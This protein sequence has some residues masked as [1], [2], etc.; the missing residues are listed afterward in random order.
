MN[1]N[2]RKHLL[3]ETKCYARNYT[4]Q[5]LQAQGYS[6]NYLNDYAAFRV[7]EPC[8][9]YFREFWRTMALPAT[10][11]AVNLICPLGCPITAQRYKEIRQL[12]RFYVHN[13]IDRYL[14]YRVW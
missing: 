10:L 14:I 4:I 11:K 9:L 12:A 13:L 7:Y 8:C 6:G 5:R 1:S 3:Y 2:Q